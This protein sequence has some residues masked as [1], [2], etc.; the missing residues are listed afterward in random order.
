MM[1]KKKEIC[2]YCLEESLVKFELG[3]TQV[4]GTCP[5]CRRNYVPLYIAE[6]LRIKK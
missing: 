1:T 6:N 3:P 5:K 4:I 2:K